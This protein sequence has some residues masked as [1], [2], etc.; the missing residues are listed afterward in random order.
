MVEWEIAQ[1]LMEAFP[2]SFINYQGEFIA[3]SGA[4]QYFNLSTC[5]NELDVKRKVLEY[6]SRSACKTLQFRTQKRNEALWEF[7]RK[8]IN[9]FLNTKFTRDDMMEIYTYL[10]NGVNSSK[11]I[12]F[13]ESGYDMRILTE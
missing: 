13:I 9:D 11:A 1:K 8:G 10:G 4:N 2:N 7:M 6:L 5:S 3:H 12:R